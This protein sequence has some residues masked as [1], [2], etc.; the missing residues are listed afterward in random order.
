VALAEAGLSLLEVGLADRE[1]HTS[2][3]VIGHAPSVQFERTVQVVSVRGS[4]S[5]TSSWNATPLARSAMRART[6]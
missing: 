6:T 3:R 5:A 1:C 2:I 4:W